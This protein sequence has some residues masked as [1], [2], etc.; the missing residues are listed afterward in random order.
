MLARLFVVLFAFVVSCLAAGMVVTLAVL[1]P[2]WSEVALGELDRGPVALVV[3]FAAIFVSGFALVPALAL[4]AIAEVM[5]IRAM[6]VYAAAGALVG[7]A[8]YA[9]LGRWDVSAWSVE[10]LSRRELEV[11]AAAGIVAGVV[12]WAIAGRNAGARA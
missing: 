3:G 5:A 9:G 8:A 6:I 11:M 12:Y 2:E 1:L 4:I 10:G 7:A